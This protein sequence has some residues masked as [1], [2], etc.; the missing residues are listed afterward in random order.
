MESGVTQLRNSVREAYSKAAIHPEEDHPFPVGREFAM[1]VGYS[2]ELLQAIPT[3]SI[4]S[5]AGVSNVSVFATLPA[6]STVVDVGCGS[7]L[8]SIIAAERVGQDGRVIGIDFSE[9]M[10]SRANHSLGGGTRKNLLF[11][12]S[13]AERL[14]LANASVDRALANGIFNLNPFRDQIITELARVL[15]PG[16]CVFGAELVLRAPLG[17]GETSDA[18]NWFS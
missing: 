2:R 6:G 14:P 16:G 1:S 5:F 18:S 7:G 9:T 4:D 11:V 8:D 17:E 13:D 15:K 12:R 3:A 10:L